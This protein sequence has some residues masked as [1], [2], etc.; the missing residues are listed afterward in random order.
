V[1]ELIYQGHFATVGLVVESARFVQTHWIEWF[2]PN[3][4]VGGLVVASWYAEIGWQIGPIDLADL[5]RAVVLCFL[6][7]FR[8]CLFDALKTWNPRAE[9]IRQLRG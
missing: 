1:P 3:A 6:M 5:V 8:G 9:R 4:V 7:L 2:I